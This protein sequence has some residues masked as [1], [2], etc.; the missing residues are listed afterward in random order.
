MNVVHSVSPGGARGRADLQ[1]SRQPSACQPQAA[2]VDELAGL[3]IHHPATRT[4]L[5]AGPHRAEVDDGTAHLTDLAATS[6]SLGLD[7][8]TF[9][10][11]LGMECV[12][13]ALSPRGTPANSWTCG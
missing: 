9:A 12:A 11:T 10:E 3:G 1:Y 7:M 4:F 6:G 2:H 5:G 13:G 8:M